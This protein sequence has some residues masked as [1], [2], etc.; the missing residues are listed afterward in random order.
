MPLERNTDPGKSTAM[1]KWPI[2]PMAHDNSG[3]ITNITCNYESGTN[4]TMGESTVDCV[5]DDGSGNKKDCQFQVIVK[6]TTLACGKR[7]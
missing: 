6:G 5:A 4:F 3:N 7:C 1:I 2:T